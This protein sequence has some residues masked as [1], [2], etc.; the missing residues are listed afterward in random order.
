MLLKLSSLWGETPT[1]SYVGRDH[2]SHDIEMKKNLFKVMHIN[3]I[4]FVYKVT[5][6]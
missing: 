2:W 3:D 6:S 1:S 4:Y 5:V